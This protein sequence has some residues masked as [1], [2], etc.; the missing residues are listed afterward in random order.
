M[1]PLPARNLGPAGD[2]GLRIVAVEKDEPARVAAF[3]AD[4]KVIPMRAE[5]VVV[6][7]R[8]EPAAHIP[9]VIRHAIPQPEGNCVAIP[10][11]GHPRA[12]AAAD[13]VG[14]AVLFVRSAKLRGLRT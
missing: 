11:A 3:T 4:A 9:A 7:A 2:G 1:M 14:G 12:E 13:E 6:I 10:E 8:K 5:A